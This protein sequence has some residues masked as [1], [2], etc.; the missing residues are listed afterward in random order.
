L[1]TREEGEKL[2]IAISYAE[3]VSQIVASTFVP[4]M[5][6]RYNGYSRCDV[7]P[8][9]LNLSSAMSFFKS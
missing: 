2:R 6:K 1:L 7:A 9:P 3:S 4:G 8:A 5:V